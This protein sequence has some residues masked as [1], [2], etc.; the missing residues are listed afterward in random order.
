MC[1]LHLP[2]GETQ[3]EGSTVHDRQSQHGNQV[4][5]IPR[6]ALLPLHPAALPVTEWGD[7][8]SPSLPRAPGM[9]LTCQPGRTVTTEAGPP[10]G[11]QLQSLLQDISFLVPGGT[12]ANT[13]PLLPGQCLSNDPGKRDQAKH[14]SSR[15]MS[16]SG[17]HRK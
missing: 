1:S 12:R 15:G 14:L 4:A 8:P 10:S 16:S 13:S 2:V 5:S 7:N 11:T 6:P 9:V 17:R 3:A